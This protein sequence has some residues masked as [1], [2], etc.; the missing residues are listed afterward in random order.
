MAQ[1]SE[2]TL[3]LLEQKNT[4]LDIQAALS[5]LLRS[6]SLHLRKSFAHVSKNLE[7]LAI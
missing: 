1:T 4:C 7:L 5:K 3:W 6:T 2:K